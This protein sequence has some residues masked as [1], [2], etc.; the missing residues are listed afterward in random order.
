MVRLPWLG[1][2]LTYRSKRTLGS[3]TSRLGSASTP[4]S[5]PW[6]PPNT[7]RA[8]LA[9]TGSGVG[10]VERSLTAQ[11]DHTES[12]PHAVGVQSVQL[13][14]HQTGPLLHSTPHPPAPALGC[15]HLKLGSWAE[16]TSEPRSDVPMVRSYPS[17]KGAS[18][19]TA[20]GGE[21]SSVGVLPTA[22]AAWL[23]KCVFGGTPVREPH[24]GPPLSLRSQ[25][26]TRE[27][28]GLRWTGTTKQ[29][30]GTKEPQE[31]V[32]YL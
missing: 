23:C 9:P 22:A 29:R 8:C 16:A 11:K 24:L 18:A 5:S 6:R 26:L 30:V 4:A 14:P 3:A 17:W 25:G 10:R 15:T 32:L 21:A 19:N 13:C 7:T 31:H 20:P 28:R 2:V 27:R 1:Q 12:S